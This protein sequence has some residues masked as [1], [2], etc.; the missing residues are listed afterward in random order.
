MITTNNK[1]SYF[2][3]NIIRK[4]T[5]FQRQRVCVYFWKKRISEFVI[6]TC[7]KSLDRR[8]SSNKGKLLSWTCIYLLKCRNPEHWVLRLLDRLLLLQGQLLHFVQYTNSLFIC[9]RTWSYFIEKLASENKSDFANATI[10]HSR[11]FSFRKFHY[12]WYWWW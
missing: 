10:L 12:W 9:L 4:S 7:L 5:L 3:F 11:Y 1:I 2:G 6:E 8:R